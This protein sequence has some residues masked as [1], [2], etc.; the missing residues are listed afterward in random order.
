VIIAAVDTVG[1]NLNG[2]FSSVAT[3]VQAP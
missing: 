2:T 1:T 3:A